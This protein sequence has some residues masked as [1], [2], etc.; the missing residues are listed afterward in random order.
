MRETDRRR[1][2]RKFWDWASQQIPHLSTDARRMRVQQ[3]LGTAD[4][5]RYLIDNGIDKAM[6]VLREA[7]S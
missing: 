7:W 6:D 1:S 2:P 4:V 3:G 5:H